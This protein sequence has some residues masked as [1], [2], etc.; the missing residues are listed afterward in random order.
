MPNTIVPTLT[1]MLSREE[2]SDKFEIVEMHNG[3][4]HRLLKE[5]VSCDSEP[6]CIKL[7][8]KMNE[9]ARSANN[10]ILQLDRI[11]KLPAV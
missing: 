2:E 8:R 10:K 3:K 9:A 7:V 4:H 6:R 11:A 1:Y 5:Y